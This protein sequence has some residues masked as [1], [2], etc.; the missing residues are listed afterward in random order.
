VTPDV[1][2]GAQKFCIKLRV[3]T[4]EGMSETLLRCRDAPQYARWVAGCHLASR[5]GSATSLGAEAQGVL[6]VQPGKEDPT[7]PSWALSRPP[8]DPQQLLPPRF[9]RKFKA[10]QLTPRLLEVLHRVGALTPVQ[11]RLRFVEAWRALPGFGLGHFVV[12]FQGAGRDEILA[13]GP[14]QLLRI[15]PASGAV[16]RSWR[17][18]DLRQWDV[19]WDSQQV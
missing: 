1:D 13:V 5:G 19:N 11:A 3:P 15:D 12:R 7:V 10:K 4:L 17:H 2:L 16:T 18:S 9:Q 6:G 14:S 8:P